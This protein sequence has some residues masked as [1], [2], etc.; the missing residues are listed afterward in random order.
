MRTLYHWRLDPFSRQARIA[1]AEKG[2]RLRLVEE[3][4]WDG[5]QAFLA[6]NPAGATPVMVVEPGARRTVVVGA[7][8]LLEY[9]EEVEPEPPLLPAH[10][11]D[12][13]EARRVA[14]WF[15]RKFDAEV[16]ATIVFEK[17]EKRF[18]QQGPPDSAVLRRGV[19]ALR[20]H[21]RYVGQLADRSGWLAGAH[22][23]IADIAAAAHISC[24]DYLGDV[25]WNAA[26]AAKAWYQRVKARPSM[27]DVLDDHLPGFPPA[28]DYADAEF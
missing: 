2:V 11:A 28:S 16:I 9:L 1:A 17:V 8:A 4:V 15:D 26:P 14:D 13:A 10:P 20:Q 25:D 5:R 24:V 18:T 6:L 22:M 27:R 12:R 3:R 23:T 21:L 7:R 19:E